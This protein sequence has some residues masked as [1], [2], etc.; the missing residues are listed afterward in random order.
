MNEIIISIIFDNENSLFFRN[1]INK[2]S[3]KLESKFLFPTVPV[4]NARGEADRLTFEK[5]AAA[6]S[7]AERRQCKGNLDT[8]RRDIPGHM[9]PWQ[10]KTVMGMKIC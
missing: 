8:R 5:R 2:K 9:L 10:N 4:V 6:S 7:V 3:K 1:M